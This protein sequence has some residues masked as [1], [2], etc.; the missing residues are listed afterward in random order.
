[1]EEKNEMVDTVGTLPDLA[2]MPLDL[3]PEQ[4][5][6]AGALLMAIRYHIDTI[7]KDPEYLKVMIEREEKM[8]FSNDPDKDLWHLKPTTVKKVIHIANEFEAFLKGERSAIQSVS[9]DGQEIEADN[10]RAQDIVE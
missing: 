9:I 2:D 6:R 1:M 8:K 7:I 4:K 3:T 10:G 5:L